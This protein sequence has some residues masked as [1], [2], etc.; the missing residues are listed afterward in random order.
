MRQEVGMVVATVCSSPVFQAE[1]LLAARFGEDCDPS[2]CILTNVKAGL[3]NW[4][5]WR[6]Y[7]SIL[8]SKR[9]LSGHSTPW[10]FTKILWCHSCKILKWWIQNTD[11]CTYCTAAT[12]V[13]CCRKKADVCDRWLV[14]CFFHRLSRIFKQQKTQPLRK[15]KS[16]VFFKVKKIHMSTVVAL[17]CFF[18]LVK[19]GAGRAYLENETRT[20]K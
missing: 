3:S 6:N 20:P 17:G 4:K 11:S 13:C 19:L 14:S 10:P 9:D 7:R 1:M 16:N 8:L 18:W 12:E 2:S 5:C 15:Q